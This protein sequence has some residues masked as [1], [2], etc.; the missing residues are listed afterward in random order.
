MG[1][2]SEVLVWDAFSPLPEYPV[3]AQH[4]L[5]VQR[6]EVIDIVLQNNKANAFNGDYRCADAA[7][8]EW[9]AAFSAVCARSWAHC[10]DC[11]A[12]LRWLLPALRDHV[13][14]SLHM[15]QC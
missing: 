15:P 7:L 1:N 6:G 2:G 14:F 9:Q 8:L 5:Q 11:W 13:T 10:H 4:V 12:G 3:K